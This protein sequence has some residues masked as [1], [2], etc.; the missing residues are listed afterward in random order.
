[1]SQIQRLRLLDTKQSGELLIHEIYR[2][3]QGESTF[4]GLPCVFIRLAVCDARCVW[5]DTP[6]A[7][8]QGERISSAAVIAK[9]LS[10]EC[11]LI[12]VTGGEPMLQ[13]EV[14]P[15]MKQLADCG[16][17]VLLETSGAHDIGPVDPRVHVIM[18]LKCPDSGECEHNLWTNLEKLKPT[19]EVKFVIASRHDFDW[20][21]NV[22]KQHHLDQKQNVLMGAVHGQ[23]PIA[24][25]AQ[26]VLESGLQIRMQ[27]QMHKFIWGADTRGV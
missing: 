25:L 26:W 17:T 27:L 8:Q 13:T 10:F 5:C 23:L 24:D 2:S 21:A 6:H 11:P 3:L 7:F 16:K 15:L 20:A 4:A 12:E 18:D 22:I 9:A 19:D 14:L 1:M